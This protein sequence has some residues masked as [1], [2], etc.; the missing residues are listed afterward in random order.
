[1]THSLFDPRPDREHSHAN[2]RTLLGTVSLLTEPV[3]EGEQGASG[4]A[5]A[6]GAQEDG[7]LV[8]LPHH[9]GEIT[10]AFED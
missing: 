3:T 5:V 8:E 7:E 6:V 1:M 9:L 4:P 10:A 2:F